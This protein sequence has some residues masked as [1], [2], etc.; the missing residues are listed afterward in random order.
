[1]EH[2]G[3]TDRTITL[4]TELILIINSKSTWATLITWSRWSLC[5]SASE[6][7]YYPS[8]F[9]AVFLFVAVLPEFFSS[10]P[11]DFGRFS[12]NPHILP[13]H[14]NNPTTPKPAHHKISSKIFTRTQ[15][16]KTAR[17]AG[18]RTFWQLCS[19]TFAR[20]R[21][22]CTNI[23]VQTSSAEKG[24]T[25]RKPFHKG[26]TT[27]KHLHKISWTCRYSYIYTL[28]TPAKHTRR[29]L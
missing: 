29:L 16:L 12:E 2:L 21:P 27:W 8:S 3:H 24:W 19:R 10:N 15:G 26:W 14:L 23:R 17:F 6:T 22:E 11:H 25:T 9:F 5:W 1:M 7:E 13:A 18:T 4:V 20:E 28:T